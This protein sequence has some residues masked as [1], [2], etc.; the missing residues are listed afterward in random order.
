MTYI[1]YVY[2]CGEDRRVEYFDTLKQCQKFIRRHQQRNWSSH[3]RI[4]QIIQDIPI[5]CMA[6][7]HS[8][9]G[10]EDFFATFM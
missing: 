10:V 1:V 9:T 6:G 4:D 3:Y 8:Y 2:T 5:S 7:F